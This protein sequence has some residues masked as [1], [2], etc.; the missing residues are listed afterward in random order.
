MNTIK[1]WKGNE[2]KRDELLEAAKL[3][4]L[5]DQRLEKLCNEVGCDT[6]EY[7]VY[8]I[9]H[10][11][12][13]PEDYEENPLMRAAYESGKAQR[14]LSKITTNLIRK[15]NFDCDLVMETPREILEG[16]E[17]Y[18]QNLSHRKVFPIHT[19]EEN[20]V[21]VGDTCVLSDDEEDPSKN[22]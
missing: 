16:P 3:C 6:F 1:T 12:N 8:A 4:V 2:N 15:E 20:A 9:N 5:W 21:E 18:Q 14:R 22:L 10:L 7:T 13:K 11:K 19:D 17:I